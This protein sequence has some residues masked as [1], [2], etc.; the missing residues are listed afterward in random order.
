MGG[1]CFGLS[2][3]FLFLLDEKTA[4]LFGLVSGCLF[5][6]GSAF[7]IANTFATGNARISLRNVH[8]LVLVGNILLLLGSIFYT[9]QGACQVVT[10]FISPP[11]VNTNSSLAI[12][13]MKFCNRA[14]DQ[15]TSLFGASFFIL[16][17]AFS[18]CFA[19]FELVK[20]YHKYHRIFA[21]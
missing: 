10:A 1:L 12:S 11:S 18:F 5:S 3:V 14:F 2:L 17:S 7:L 16:G 8:N 9:L 15:W 6:I 20:T 13:D 21:R 19:V 4:A